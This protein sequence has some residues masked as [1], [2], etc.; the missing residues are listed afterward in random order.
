MAGNDRLWRL[1]NQFVPGDA[2]LCEG[3]ADAF[4]PEQTIVSILYQRLALLVCVALG[5][6]SAGPAW[7]QHHGGF[8]DSYRHGGYHRDWGHILPG[9][10]D[11]PGLYYSYG[12]AHYYAPVPPP[13]HVEPSYV[14]GRPVTAT[15]T[16]TP[17]APQSVKL[18]FGGFRQIEDLSARLVAETNRWCLDMNYNYRHN[19]DF[20]ATYRAA[21]QILQAAN[22]VHAAEHREDH[23]AIRKELA[24]TERLFHQVEDRVKTWVR[25]ENRPVGEN[26]INGKTEVIETIL[27]HLLYDVGITPQHSTVVEEQAPPP[28]TASLR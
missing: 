25:E 24:A 2:L 4:D 26:G 12:G 7:A 18:E 10:H 5:S 15:S 1:S 19:P 22:Y 11:D 8:Y 16:A 28:P 9:H 3:R 21:Y 20:D 17:I 14:V 23:G 27:H 13:A 6:F